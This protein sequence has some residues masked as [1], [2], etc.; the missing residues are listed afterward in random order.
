[1]GNGAQHLLGGARHRGH[2]HNGQRHAPGQRREVL[3]LGH[4]QRIA[5]DAHHDR[6]HA[7]QHIGG[8]AHAPRRRWCPRH[9]RPDRRPRQCPAGIPIRLA[10]ARM[11]PEPT[12]E[13]AMPPPVSPTGTGD[14][15][16]E[17]PVQRAGALVDQVAQ[18]GDQRHQHHNRAQD[19]ERRHQVV[20]E[21]AARLEQPLVICGTDR[22]R[23]HQ[24]VLAVLPRVTA[25]TS[26]RAIAFT[27]MVTRKSARPISI[28]ALR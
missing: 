11:I 23:W 13:F 22:K 10:I 1:M 7:I 25:H 3:L 19:G 17:R 8:K 4:D 5:G 24:A 14:V 6:R 26:S 2:H 12:M 18:H 16:K 21:V 9:T 28:S 15:R 20:G 27:T